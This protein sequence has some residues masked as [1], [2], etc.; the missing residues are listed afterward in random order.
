MVSPIIFLTFAL[1]ASPWENAPME[2]DAIAAPVPL[3]LDMQHV[4]KKIGFKISTPKKWNQIPIQND[5]RWIVG[6]FK[7]N[8]ANHYTD[9]A[10]GYTF[11][12]K[13]EL[14]MIAFVGESVKVDIELGLDKDKDKEK[15]GSSVAGVL[16]LDN[17]YKNYEEYLKKTYSGGGWYFDEETTKEIRGIEVTAY[18]IKVEKSSRGGP[19]HITTWV[20]HLGHADVAIQFE[21]FE[22]AYPKLKK[23]FEARLKS[24]KA[25]ERT[26]ARNAASTG[27]REFLND[28]DTPEKRK[29]L[30]LKIEKEQHEK[31]LANLPDD[32]DSQDEKEFLVLSHVKKKHTKKVTD[33]VSAMFS[34]LD[35]NL[36]YIGP[37]EYV[38]R[39]I[40][41][42]CKDT[43]ELR[44]FTSGTGWS[45]TNIEILTC[46][47]NTGWSN[48]LNGQINDRTFT[49]WFNEKDRELYNR[50][51]TWLKVGIDSMLTSGQLKG[52]RMIFEPDQQDKSALREANG[53]G[54][55]ILPSVMLRMSVD[56]M[57]SSKGIYYQFGA[58]TR[59]LLAGKGAKDK[60]TKGLVREYL[61]HLGDIIAEEKALEEANDGMSN[62]DEPETEEEEDAAFKAKQNAW[63][64]RADDIAKAVFD[65]TFDDWSDKDWE[66][67]DK[68]YLRT[69]K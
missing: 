8:K 44:I 13:P 12:H 29:D 17:P 69:I 4:D 61:T 35:K 25:I 19:K 37:E 27:F 40:V 41:R 28:A 55:I 59:Y 56:E 42:I 18:E 48:Y 32:W 47:D 46:R 51:P 16:Y 60:L 26:E 10:F 14:T 45:F 31:A 62:E 6:R 53:N 11:D 54:T 9:K 34:W 68:A 63:K 2:F 50:I 57:R 38:R 39:P 67:L 22:T 52:S 49:F 66:N 5:E 15:G 21:C 36:S 64:E 20:Y 24:F 1:M 3:M 58:F 30:R 7:S 33:Q 23:E 43:E 65:R